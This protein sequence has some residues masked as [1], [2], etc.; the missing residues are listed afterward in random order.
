MVFQFPIFK[1]KKSNYDSKL[2][3]SDEYSSQVYIFLLKFSKK[4]NRL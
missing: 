3:N 1:N 4:N 2:I